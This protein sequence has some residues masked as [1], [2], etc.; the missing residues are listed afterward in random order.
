M[1]IAIVHDELMRRGGAEQV[2][3]CMHSAFPDATIYTMAYQPEATY[4]YFKGT[5]IRTSWYNKLVKNEEQMRKFFFPLGWRAMKA[6]KIDD[7]VDLV[8]IST[9]YCAKYVKFPK[10]ALVIAY[11]Y[12]PFRLAWNPQSY[13]QYLNAKGLK[14]AV[15]NKVVK[16][17]RKIDFKAA[18]KI[19][20]FIAMTEETKGRIQ[21]SYKP[22]QPITLIKPPANIH[23]F[24]VTNDKK[25]YYLVVSRFE[26]YKKVDLVI[27]AF[28]EMGLPLVIV[29]KG[30]QEKELKS[31]AKSNITF[32]TGVSSEELKNLYSNCKAF[33][34]PQHEDYGITPLEAN[35][36]GRPVV[37]YGKGGVLDTMIPYV[38]DAKKATAVL[39]PNQ[40]TED[41]IEAIQTLEKLEFDP[42]FIRT[43]AE[44]FREEVFIEQL[45]TF[46][47]NKY[48]EQGK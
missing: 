1:K 12:T 36:S 33:I 19:D 44:N 28:N 11:C 41:L 40:T 10:N 24:R 14:K 8:L 48:Q 20:L 7:D 25:E 47:T 27:D 18:Q 3:R 32:K 35:A 31:R 16:F 39:F 43:H 17:L 46:V 15:F 6:L 13:A 5:K 45:K 2:V 34:F 30:S 37:A 22:T 21:E 4:P 23:N 26:F 38:D 42:Q 29:G 9:T